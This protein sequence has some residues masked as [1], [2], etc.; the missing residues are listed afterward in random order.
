MKL[1]FY[2]FQ[3]NEQLL[4]NCKDNLQVVSQ[5]LIQEQ[6][7]A[8]KIWVCKENIRILPLMVYKIIIKMIN[9]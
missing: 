2:D 4:K 5:I 1:G 6:M 7:K 8:L 9:L 3:R